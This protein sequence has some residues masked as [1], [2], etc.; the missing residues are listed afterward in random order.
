MD[1]KPQPE[2]K[3]IERDYKKPY[4]LDKK[5][6]RLDKK[7]YR[8]D[9]KLQPEHKNPYRFLVP[10]HLSSRPLPPLT[11]RGRLLT[12]FPLTSCF[13]S[14][15][16]DNYQSLYA[17]LFGKWDKELAGYHELYLVADGLLELVPFDALVLPD[18]RYWVERQPIRRLRAG[19]DLVVDRV[20]GD[21][22]SEPPGGA[23]PTLVALGG[24]DYEEFPVVGEVPGS[25]TG[26]SLHSS[27]ATH[28]SAT[29]P[30]ARQPASPWLVNRRLRAERG[31]FRDLPATGPEAAAVVKEYK[32]ITG[33]PAE[34]WQGAK[35]GEGRL[36]RLLAPGATPPRVLHLAT[37][38][39]FLPKQGGEGD[40]ITERPMT[41][42]GLAL[43][44]ANRGRAGELGPDG[45]D[46]ILYGLEAQS[47][48]LRGTA[49][50]VL[51]ACDTGRGEVDVSDGVY[52][53]TRALGIAGARN[54]LMTLWPLEDR[55]AAEFMRDFYRNW[56]GDSDA[57]NGN[58]DAVNGNKD[59]MDKEAVYVNEEAVRGNR[60]A[61]HRDKDAINRVS[62]GAVTPA[63][64]L[65]QTRLAWIRS[66]DIRRRNRKFWAPYVLV[67]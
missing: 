5:P 41:L 63:E 62:T 29:Q 19:R 3:K 26:G 32:G 51:S 11:N 50:V 21:E 45:E 31:A 44:G 24:I 13:G 4:R 65:R 14:A 1:K 36:K 57:V 42:G 38:G 52:G 37:H 17:Q 60:D 54:V 53:L 48:N 7:P 64:A 27:P 67:E 56:L 10:A 12:L 58:K 66:D 40:L 20:A 18:G 6:Y 9:K 47:L 23:H 46:G 28:P 15:G 39:F 8:L 61:I 30:V 16:G 22:R 55:L 33:L 34:R 43:A 2:H 25:A 35:A 49:L 59:S